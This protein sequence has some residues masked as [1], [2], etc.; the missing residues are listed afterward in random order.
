M[1]DKD[2]IEATLQSLAE[3]A[4]KASLVAPRSDTSQNVAGFDLKLPEL[5]NNDELVGALKR[6]KVPIPVYADGRPSR[7][8]LLYLYKTNVMPRPQRNRW[9]RGRNKRPGVVQPA[10]LQQEEEE[11]GEMEV[12]HEGQNWSVNGTDT[13][14]RKRSVY[15]I[16]VECLSLK[17]RA[18]HAKSQF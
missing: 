7:E 9:K 5:M 4:K 13:T 16:L 10:A 14:Q 3:E 1:V 12:D 6:I 11:D 18:E 8:R 2:K 17:Q 15:Y